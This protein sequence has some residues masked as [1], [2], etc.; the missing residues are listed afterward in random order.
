MDSSSPVHALEGR[1]NLR[2]GFLCLLL[3]AF[4]LVAGCAKAPVK[5]SEFTEEDTCFYCKSPIER[6]DVNFAAEFITSSG[7]VRKFDDISCL[8]A[9]AKKVG[10]KNIEAFYFSDVVSGKL[11]P[12]E[13]VQFVRCDKLNTPKKGGI[14]AFADSTKADSFITKYQAYKAEKVKLDDLLQ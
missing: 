12:A 7:F 8:V 10:K 2:V 4:V 5:P 13:Q 6:K 9:N 14:I 3:C 1:G 11:F